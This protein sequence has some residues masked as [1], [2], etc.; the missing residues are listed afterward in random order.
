[1]TVDPAHKSYVGLT[2]VLINCLGPRTPLVRSKAATP[3]STM[4]MI[5][6]D[7]I[8]LSDEDHAMESIEHGNGN[9]D[10]AATVNPSK[11]LFHAAS[12]ELLSPVLPFHGLGNPRKGSPSRK[13]LNAQGYSSSSPGVLSQSRQLQ[14]SVPVDSDSMDVIPARVARVQVRVPPPPRFKPLPYPSSRTG[15]VYDD[16][17]RFHAEDEVLNNNPPDDIHPEDPRR[18]YAIF[19]EIRQAG[20][21]QD[22][23]DS[24]DE[25]AESRDNKCWRI[26]TRHA[27]QAEICLVHTPD[28][29]LY[30]EALQNKT[31]LE[32]QALC[33]DKD[34]VYF[35][36]STFDSALL[37]AGGAIE[38]CRAVVMGQVRNAIAIIR[39]PGHH[40]EAT[41]PS[42]FCIF[43]NVPIAARVC[44]NDFPETCRK[45]IILDWDVHH[46]NGIQHAFYDDPNVLY[47][48]LHVFRGGARN[49]DGDLTYC[50]EGPGLGRNVNI[51]WEEHY[52]GDAEYIYAFQQVVIPIVSEFDP[53][54]VIISA[55]FDAA[56]GDALGMCHVSP[57]GYAH[58]THMLMRVAEGKM[59]VTLMLQPPDRL[60]DD[61]NPK[62]SAVRTIEQVK[63]AQSKFWK[64][65]YPKQLDSAIPASP[66]TSR[67]HEVLRKFQSLN[68]AEEYRMTPLQIIKDE[69]KDFFEHNV[70]ATPYFTDKRPLLVIFHDPPNLTYS[71]DPVTGK[72]EL[73]NIWLADV[74]EKDYIGWAIKNGF[75]VIDVNVPK[76]EPIKDDDGEFIYSDT[77]DERAEKTKQLASYI[78][79]NYI[80]PHDATQVFFLGIG[81]AYV[82]LVD[83][84]RSNEACTDENSV[85][86]SLIAFVADTS[87]QSIRRP[88]DDNVASWYESHSMIFVQ[89]DHLCWDPSRGHKRRKKWGKLIRSEHVKLD[90]MLMQH[91]EEVQQYLLAKKA[92]F[93]DH[94]DDISVDDDSKQPLRSP[95][96]PSGLQSPQGSVPLTRN[97][98]AEEGRSRL[99]PVAYFN[100]SNSR[101]GTLS[102]TAPGSPLRQGFGRG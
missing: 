55:G 12:P 32:L 37:A 5:D 28:H 74:V 51:P 18:I 15:L 21:V 30:V 16:R 84:L 85:V 8:V 9:G 46:G 2:Y 38:A 67:L 25:D 65:M 66:S 102:P 10:H 83:L 22:S 95:P 99:P 78:W 100:V 1:M 53:D 11:L 35:N 87:L 77:H 31:T 54:L 88:T 4:A 97:G 63:R 86:E 24:D 33:R 94:G 3:S 14:N 72:I 42:G 50:G 41:E 98:Y 81:S 23:F 59:A 101:T 76:I 92:P 34:S 93:V 58:M 48:S 49:P 68:M 79:E 44:Q 60:A 43:N 90:D 36:N 71:P 6:E 56:E 17:M 20:L 73:H 45:I 57:A 7:T 39:P 61:L 47:I 91:K 29:Y 75:E 26:H 52:M 40:A 64:C 89:N 69:L 13:P 96:L 82:G 19:H 70:V 80:E 27:T 62:E